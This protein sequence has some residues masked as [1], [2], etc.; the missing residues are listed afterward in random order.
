MIIG[1]PPWEVPEAEP[2]EFSAS[3]YPEISDLNRGK[4]KKWFE[5]KFELPVKTI[6]AD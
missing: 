6:V 5:N 2:R 3:L 4:F 1:N